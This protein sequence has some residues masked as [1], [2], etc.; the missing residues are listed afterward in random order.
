M[1]FPLVVFCVAL[2]WPVVLL[3]KTLARIRS[4]LVVTLAAQSSIPLPPPLPPSLVMAKLPVV[5]LQ[6]SAAGDACAFCLER[7]QPQDEVR[8]LANCRHTFHRACTD[9]WVAKGQAQCCPLCRSYILPP[10]A[11]AP[12]MVVGTLTYVLVEI[13]TQAR[14]AMETCVHAWRYVWS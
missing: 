3:V 10:P 5:Q 7:L 13:Y 2:P 9:R 8:L 6:A 14:E 12:S 4:F 11:A 1:T